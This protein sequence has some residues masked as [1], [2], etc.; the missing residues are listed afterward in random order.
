MPIRESEKLGYKI[1][2]KDDITQGELEDWSSM[3]IFGAGAPILRGSA[4]RGAIRA[5]LIIEISHPDIT[6]L[7]DITKG[8]K[9]PSVIDAGI[10]RITP[11]KPLMWFGVKLIEI[12]NELTYFD[13]N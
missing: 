8:S 1:V 6:A 4:L 13:P 5:G 7:I 10:K 12:Y 2:V 11:V 9:D 3:M